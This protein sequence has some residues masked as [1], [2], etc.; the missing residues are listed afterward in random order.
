M[1][2][3]FLKKSIIKEACASLEAVGIEN[4]HN[5]CRLLLQHILNL[6]LLSLFQKK[7]LT[8]EEKKAFETLLE[9]RLKREPMAFILGE[10][11]FWSLKF[12][13]S[14][15]TLIPRDDSETLIDLILTYYPSPRAFK[16]ILDLGTGTGCLLLTLL[17]EYPE[18]FGIGV[19]ISDKSTLLAQRNSER[20]GLEKRA[21]FMVGSWGEALKG[22]FDLIISNPPYIKK[23]DMAGLMPEVRLYEPHR[24][25]EAGE[26]GLDDYRRICAQLPQLLSPHGCAVFELGMGQ[27][28]DVLK[29][30]KLYGLKKK[31]CKKD[32]GGI[33]RALILKRC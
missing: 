15:E 13:V 8:E 5:E 18:A 14:P 9:R 17:K 16:N 26:D 31:A 20:N 6:D 11:G 25:L 27:E 12:Y 7:F 32:Y 21:S 3:V 22:S 33:I 23:R 28:E 2:E 19:D 10:K 29:I 4:P 24:A 1:A 30:A